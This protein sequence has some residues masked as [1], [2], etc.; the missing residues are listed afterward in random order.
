MKPEF[1]HVHFTSRE[2]PIAHAPSWEVWLQRKGFKVLLW[3]LSISVEGKMANSLM[4]L[5]LSV[6]EPNRAF[7]FTWPVIDI[8]ASF[9]QHTSVLSA[10]SVLIGH[11]KQRSGIIHMFAAENSKACWQLVLVM[12]HKRSQFANKRKGD[13]KQKMQL[14]KHSK[15]AFQENTQCCVV[16]NSMKPCVFLTEIYFTF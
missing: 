12:H 8:D 15:N 1:W 14:A 4:T 3:M 11:Y 6:T 2:F 9:Y 16:N 5:L 7:S 10:F 13:R